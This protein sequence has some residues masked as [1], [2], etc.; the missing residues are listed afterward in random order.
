[1]MQMLAPNINLPTHLFHISEQ[2]SLMALEMV[3]NL[4]DTPELTAGL[5]KLM[6][7][8]DCFVRTAVFAADPNANTVW[9]TDR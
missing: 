3:E 4:P 8:K 6:E 5:R 9:Y 2:F 7:A 1:M